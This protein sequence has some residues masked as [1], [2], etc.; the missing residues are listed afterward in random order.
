M[1]IG[2]SI[3]FMLVCFYIQII[4]DQ[5]YWVC[6]KVCSSFALRHYRKPKRTFWPAQY[7]EDLLDKA[8]QG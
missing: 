2:H 8:F 3:I 5:L 6:Q 4:N 7:L 1:R